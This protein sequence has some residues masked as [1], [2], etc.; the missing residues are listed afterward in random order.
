MKKSF[1]N[2]SLQPARTG[3]F[4]HLIADLV[5]ETDPSVFGC[6]VRNDREVFSR[7]ITP[8]WQLTE[9]SYSYDCATIA[10]ENGELLGF[11]QGF[12]G[13][14]HAFLENRSG[15]AAAGAF[16]RDLLEHMAVCS[17]HLNYVIPYVPKSA[18][19]V[20]LLSICEESRG[21]GIGKQ[22]LENAFQR[23]AESGFKTV[24]LDVYE[25]NP[26]VGFYEKMGMEKRLETRL[27]AMQAFCEIPPHFRMV[28]AL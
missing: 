25:G 15:K 19:Y 7:W 6:L 21:Q 28:K 24:Q 5:F 16:S 23:A 20:H 13:S 26:A 14:Q 10:L 11:E 3:I 17:Q 18:Y 2:V 1:T 27:P 8:L 4:D 12:A 9:C 22:L